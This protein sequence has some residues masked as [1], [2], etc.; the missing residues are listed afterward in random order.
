MLNILYTRKVCFAAGKGIPKVEI[1][2]LIV[3]NLIWRDYNV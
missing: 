1:G 3:A 2:I